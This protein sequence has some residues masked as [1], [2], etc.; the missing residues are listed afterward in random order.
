[1]LKKYWK[2]K[3]LSTHFSM[4]KSTFCTRDCHSC[5]NQTGAHPVFQHMGSQRTDTPNNWDCSDLLQVKDHFLEGDCHCQGS[6][7]LPAEKLGEGAAPQ[8][9]AKIQLLAL[10]FR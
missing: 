4:L 6:R 7:V 8:Q 1:M 5:K 2:S 3:T 9:S 10:A